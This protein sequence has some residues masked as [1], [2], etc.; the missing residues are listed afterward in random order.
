MKVVSA[1]EFKHHCLALL[2]ELKQT[3][4]GL[5]ITKHGK[6]VAQVLPYTEELQE[7]PL[8]DSI[9]FENDLVSPVDDLWDAE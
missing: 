8:K 6:P 9:L 5:L 3:R 2:N 1:T 4:E 7:N